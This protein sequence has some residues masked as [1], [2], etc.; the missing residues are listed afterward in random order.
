MLRHSH[1]LWLVVPTVLL[2]GCPLYPS[3]CD[4][5][6][7]CGFNYV[8]DAPSGQCVPAHQTPP[9]EPPGSG[10]ERCMTSADCDP[11]LI[12]DRYDR[13]VPPPG[14]TGGNGGES[15]VSTAGGESGSAA[16]GAGG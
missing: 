14:A 6:D 2:G 3:G 16:A 11:G 13:C 4:T 10:P 7:D 12:C 15:G 1:A 9:V 5:N 8:C